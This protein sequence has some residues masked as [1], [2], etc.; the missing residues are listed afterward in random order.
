[1]P[2]ASVSHRYW[3]RHAVGAWLE[4]LIY[5]VRRRRFGL[6]AKCLLAQTAYLFT[7][8]L[9]W[10]WKPI[11]TLWSCVLPYLLSSLALMFGNW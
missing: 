3:V 10:R 4:L 11:A 6:F 8:Q 7:V 5:A 1:M 2:E 9:L